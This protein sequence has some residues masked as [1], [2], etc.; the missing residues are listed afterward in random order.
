MIWVKV[1]FRTGDSHGEVRPGGRE[2]GSVWI[3]DE[4]PAQHEGA[5]EQSVTQAHIHKG[6]VWDCLYRPNDE[7]YYE[8]LYNHLFNPCRAIAIYWCMGGKAQKI[9]DVTH[10]VNAVY[11]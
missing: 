6:T 4:E 8:C 5:G 11:P 3:S 2:S 7:Y 10:I 9:S 1:C